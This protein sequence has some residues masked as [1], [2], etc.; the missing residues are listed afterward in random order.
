MRDSCEESNDYA[1]GYSTCETD[2]RHVGWF[3]LVFLQERKKERESI[4]KIMGGR[5]FFFV[6]G[7]RF[8]STA[9]VFVGVKSHAAIYLRGIS[10]AFSCLEMSLLC[11]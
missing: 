3:G 1:E 10:N 2:Q 8:A 11:Q 5:L 9:M 6:S 7:V 4:R